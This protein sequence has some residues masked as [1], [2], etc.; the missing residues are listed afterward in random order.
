MATA[1]KS[2]VFLKPESIIAELGI[3]GGMMIG[4]FGVGGAA[5]FAVPLATKVGAKGQ[6]FMVDILKSALSSALSL[7]KMRG[8]TNCQAVW[9]NLEIYGAAHGIKDESLDAGVIVNVLSQSTKP[10][11]ILAE[12][13][14]T[15]KSGAKLVI[16]DWLPSATMPI[17][18][19]KKNRLAADYVTEL[20]KKL[21]YAPL[22]AFSAGRY[23]WG[24]ILI[25]T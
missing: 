13:H 14:R 2:D 11:D 17:A 9:S 3:T 4:D 24:L 10:K 15:M 12:V 20:G 7:V 6:V 25:R 18:P 16:V 21:G 23:H 1:T 8:L 22:K 5:N 19:E